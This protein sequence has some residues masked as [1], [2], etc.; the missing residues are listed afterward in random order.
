MRESLKSQLKLSYD[1]K[2]CLTASAEADL[3]VHNDMI[4]LRY[5]GSRQPFVMMGLT[6]KRVAV[7][8]R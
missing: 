8:G 1:R 4:F 2:A 5:T 6:S 7:K 3:V